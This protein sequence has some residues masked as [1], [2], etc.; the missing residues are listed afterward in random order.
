MRHARARLSKNSKKLHK[1]GENQRSVLH[2]GSIQLEALNEE[3]LN[4]TP[5]SRRNVVK[6]RRQVVRAAVDLTIAGA[7]AAKKRGQ[8]LRWVVGW[9]WGC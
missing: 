8:R 7:E 5:S 4:A 3:V 1:V 2:R 9:W 6:E